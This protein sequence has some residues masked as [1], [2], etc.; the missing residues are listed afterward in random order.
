M[1][2]QNPDSRILD[3]HAP[4]ILKAASRLCMLRK[5]NSSFRPMKRH[6]NAQKTLTTF[7]TVDGDR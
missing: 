1:R 7:V 3:Q 5:T 6:E 2:A 4:D